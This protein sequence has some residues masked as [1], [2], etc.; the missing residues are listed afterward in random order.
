MTNYERYERSTAPAP[1]DDYTLDN[2]MIAW[3][4]ILGVRSAN[5]QQ[6]VDAV[7]KVLAL[8]AEYSATGPIFEDGV[9][10]GTPQSALQFSL[11]GDA[12]ILVE[13]NQ[14]ET[15]AA[16]KLALIWRVCDLSTK[17]FESGLLHRGA[18]TFGPVEC[19]KE[20]GVHVITGKGV[21]RAATLE[22]SIKCSGLFFDEKC[23]PIL[24]ERQKQLTRQATV[25]FK[26][27]LPKC[28][29]FFTAKY[30]SGVLVATRGGLEA[31]EES[32]Q[33]AT[34]HKYVSKSKKMT[35]YLRSILNR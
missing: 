27:D 8:A 11:V 24:E 14:P 16:S 6:I 30:L 17:L 23:I 1:F 26:K 12:L 22:S 9:F 32:L 3:I 18:I 4:D 20:D 7:R 13:K 21:V 2:G 35:G 33:K 31:W 19:F 28:F 15:P 10:A 5:H 25:V 29:W 34:P